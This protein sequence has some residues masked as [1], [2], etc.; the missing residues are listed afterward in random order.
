MFDVLENEKE[1]CLVMEL[2]DYNLFTGLKE[3]LNEKDI[4]I[5]LK[6]TAEAILHCHNNDICHRDIKL[7]NIMFNIDEWADENENVIQWL[8]K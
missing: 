6:E 3:D 5:I 2:F 4:R 1:I 8:K 7:E